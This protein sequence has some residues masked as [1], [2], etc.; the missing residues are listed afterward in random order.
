MPGVLR[1]IIALGVIGFVS[2]IGLAEDKLADST[3]FYPLNVGDS[4]DYKTRD[5]IRETRKVSSIEKVNG[6]PCAKVVQMVDGKER[7]TEFIGVKADGVYRLAF[8][9]AKPE[10]PVLFLKLPLKEGDS[11]TVEGKATGETFKATFKVGAEKTIKV[12]AGEFKAF[13]VSTD[14]LVAAGVKASS[15]IYYAPNVGVVMHEFKSGNQTTISELEKFTP[16]GK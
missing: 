12:P 8:G 7:G 9:I 4:W 3:P 10:N 15:T 14:D 6:I 1:F 16:K 11:W 2:A 5:G 13:P